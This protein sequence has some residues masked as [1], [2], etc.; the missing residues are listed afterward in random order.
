MSGSQRKTGTPAASASTKV[1][2]ASS[3]LYEVRT[4]R[5]DSRMAFWTVS[6]LVLPWNLAL[7]RCM[8]AKLLACKRSTPSPYKSNLYLPWTLLRASKNGMMRFSPDRRECQMI[9]K[10]S[11]GFNFFRGAWGGNLI[12]G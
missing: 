1:M 10:V 12:S 8:V 2:G 11:P 3:E 4:S 9:R 7:R 5:C 6:N